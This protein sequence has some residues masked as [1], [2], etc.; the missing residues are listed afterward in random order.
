MAT[1]VRV[2]GPLFD[3][4][5][6]L[7]IHEFVDELDKHVALGTQ[8]ILI[9]YYHEFFQNPT[10]YYESQTVVKDRAFADRSVNDSGVIYGPWLA[11]TGS[12]NE[13]SRFK[14]YKHWRLALQEGRQ[15]VKP[16]AEFLWPR[17][18]SRMG[19]IP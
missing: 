12:R 2:F 6:A 4:K 17:F 1:N 15:M 16:A 7:A 19:G 14:G 5:A 13:T 9:K 8:V 18:A 3:G 10:G 11:G